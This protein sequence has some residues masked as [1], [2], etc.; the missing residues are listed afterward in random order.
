MVE[1]GNMASLSKR[2]LVR[3]TTLA[4]STKEKIN[5]FLAEEHNRFLGSIKG[6]RASD[7]VF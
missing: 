6:K 7:I 2:Y 5:F 3:L 1:G 4:E